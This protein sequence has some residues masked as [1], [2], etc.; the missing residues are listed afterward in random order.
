MKRYC[1]STSKYAV[2]DTKLHNTIKSTHPMRLT[3][4]IAVTGMTS[5]ITLSYSES[6]N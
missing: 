5:E 1:T 6:A 3:R 2:L 4:I